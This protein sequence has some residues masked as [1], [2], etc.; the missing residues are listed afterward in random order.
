MM[1]LTHA[2]NVV[3]DLELVYDYKRDENWDWAKSMREDYISFL[4]TKAEELGVNY[5]DHADS[6]TPDQIKAMKMVADDYDRQA[7]QMEQ[8]EQKREAKI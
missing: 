1:S 8:A 6:Y 4:W 5:E 3:A 2:Y 7:K